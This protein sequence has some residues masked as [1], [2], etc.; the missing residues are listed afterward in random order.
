[1]A[2]ASDPNRYSS[3]W[4][5]L[6]LPHDAVAPA[7]EIAFLLR[8]LGPAT[9]GIVLDAGAGTGRHALPLAAA[10]DGHVLALDRDHAACARCRARST[11]IRSARREAVGVIAADLETLPLRTASLDAVLS[12]WQSFGYGGHEANARM[13]EGFARVL[14]PGGRLVVDLYHRGAQRALPSE[15]E[16]E[17]EGCRVRERRRWIGTRL[18]VELRYDPV[19]D[20]PARPAGADRFSWEVY[21]P[22]ELTALA[23]R[24]GFRLELACAAFT[25]AIPAGPDHPRMQLVYVRE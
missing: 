15:R 19:D 11:G 8:Q 10:I 1:M 21:E 2:P 18:E 4:F 14:R 20:G 23:A 9:S 17:R 25:E 16:M 22:G 6:F 5:D 24:A 12:L 3:R 13:L 7:A